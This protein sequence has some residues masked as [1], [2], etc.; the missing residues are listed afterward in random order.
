MQYRLI[1]DRKLCAV[2]YVV[3]VHALKN[4]GLFHSLP[5][6]GYGDG[7]KPF[8]E[9]YPDIH[10]N[11]SHCRDVAVCCLSDEEVGVDVENVFAFDEELARAICND[12][13]YRWIGSFPEPGER[14]KNLT[15]LWTRKESVV[16]WRGT[17]LNCDPREILRNGFSDTPDDDFHISSFYNQSGNFYVSACTNRH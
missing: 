11:F 3:L 12:D 1:S 5:E 9:N 4:E 15:K 16:K 6:F 13:E 2:A 17:G 10:F 7:G 14:A 8:L